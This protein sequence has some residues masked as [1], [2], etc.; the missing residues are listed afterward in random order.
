MECVAKQSFLTS[1]V[2]HNNLFQFE[3]RCVEKLQLWDLRCGEFFS[4]PGE[5]STFEYRGNGWYGRPYSAGPWHME[6]RRDFP[7][8]RLPVATLRELVG[9]DWQHVPTC[10]AL[11]D[12]LL[13]AARLLWTLGHRDRGE[14]WFE[15]SQKLP[16]HLGKESIRTVLCLVWHELQH[17]GIDVDQSASFDWL[18]NRPIH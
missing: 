3:E 18:K 7:V 13:N 1:V 10:K 2:Q 8:E 9:A 6:C 12:R 17:H 5:V 15:R 11:C 16:V 14:F 4:K